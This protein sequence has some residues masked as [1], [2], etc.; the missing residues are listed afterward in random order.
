MYMHRSH[1]DSTRGIADWA[2]MVVT[3]AQTW[4]LIYILMN[5]SSDFA[6]YYASCCRNFIC[7]TFSE[8]F[9]ILEKYK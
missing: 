5:Y 9:I 2:A 7:T 8:Y 1:W 6:L 4:F 3:E